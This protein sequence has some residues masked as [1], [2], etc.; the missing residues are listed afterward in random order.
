MSGRLLTVHK[1]DLPMSSAPAEILPL[2]LPA[3]AKILRVSE[4]VGL[5]EQP[6]GAGPRLYVW[7][8]V[9][10]EEQFQELRYVV[11]VDTDRDFALTKLSSRDWEHQTSV[12]ALNGSI[13]IH[14]WISRPEGSDTKQVS[15]DNE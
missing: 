8:L 11:T 5:S 10:P 3:G 6:Y 14:V 7:A 2:R 9:D 1:Y 15:A 12:L 4:Q 13:M